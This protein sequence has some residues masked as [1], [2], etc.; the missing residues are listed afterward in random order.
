MLTTLWR[1]WG[2][3][4]IVQGLFVPVEGGAG[5]S[6]A[7]VRPGTTFSA[8]EMIVQVGLLREAAPTVWAF[9]LLALVDNLN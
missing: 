6:L 4:F 9:D 7:R 1:Q 5:F 2:G 3:G 8:V